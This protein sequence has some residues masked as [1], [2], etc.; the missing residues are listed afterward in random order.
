MFSLP[1]V[2]LAA[3]KLMKLDPERLDPR[4][5]SCRQRPHSD[6]AD[7]DTNSVRLERA[8][9][10]R[11]GAQ[12]RLRRAAGTRWRDVARHRSL[13][14]SSGFFTAG[15]PGRPHVDVETLRSAWRSVPRPPMQSEGL[16]RRSF[17]RRRRSWPA[18]SRQGSRLA[19]SDYRNRNRDDGP[20]LRADREQTREMVAANQGDR[21]SQPAV[22]NGAGDG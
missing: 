4:G 7:P 22:H 5:R 8:R 20:W 3:G 21:G 2:A 17:T 6:G 13:K 18:S 11:S 1:A 12:C 9:G 16:S 14:G 15:R 19:R 10:R